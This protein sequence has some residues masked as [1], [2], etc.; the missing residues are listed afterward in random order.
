M[1][2]FKKKPQN[3]ERLQVKGDNLDEIKTFLNI[4]VIE[5]AEPYPG[6]YRRVAFQHDG[7]IRETAVGSFL[8]KEKGTNNLS[9]YKEKEFEQYFEPVDE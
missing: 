8:V 4:S 7:I 2:L 1:K 3:Y 9:I 6:R 5:Y